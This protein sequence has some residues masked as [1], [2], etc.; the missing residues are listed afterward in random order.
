M[1]EVF[2]HKKRSEEKASVHNI[3]TFLDFDGFAG[4]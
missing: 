2:Y 4:C 3:S 1:A